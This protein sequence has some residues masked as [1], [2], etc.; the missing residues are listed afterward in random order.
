[1]FSISKS[2][3]YGLD[4]KTDYI[5]LVLHLMEDGAECFVIFCDKI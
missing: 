1:M 3:E 4:I 2:Q 5:V